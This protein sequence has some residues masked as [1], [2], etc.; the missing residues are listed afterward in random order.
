MVIDCVSLEGL[1]RK[2]IE[3]AAV[4]CEL[5]SMQCRLW[6]AA[7]QLWLTNS[8]RPL[9]KIPDF[10]RYKPVNWSA[11]TS[12]DLVTTLFYDSTAQEAQQ[13]NRFGDV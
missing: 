13:S 9:R 11:N 3:L 5:C 8:W 10:H 12:S 4:G 6:H 7:R 2:K 1:K